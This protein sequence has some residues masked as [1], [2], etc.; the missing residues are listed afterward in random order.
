[1]KVEFPKIRIAD[2]SKHRCS[3]VASATVVVTLAGAYLILIAP[4]AAQKEVFD[5]RIKQQQEL[6]AKYNQKLKQSQS[7]QDNLAR[8]EEE[9]KRHAKE[10]VPGDRPVP[11]RRFSGRPAFIKGQG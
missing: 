6:I 8:H 2:I 7:I 11:A 1:M 9:L 5:S 10:A 4:I 3:I